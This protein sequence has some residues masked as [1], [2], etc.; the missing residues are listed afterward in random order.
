MLAYGALPPS[1]KQQQIPF[2]RGSDGDL[3][4]KH[5]PSMC[6]SLHRLHNLGNC[7]WQPWSGLTLRSRLC[8]GKAELCKREAAGVW[9]ACNYLRAAFQFD[10]QVLGDL[11]ASYS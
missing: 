5:N 1:I 4:R 10:S 9:G 6:L 8:D 11:S 7:L 2:L 3:A